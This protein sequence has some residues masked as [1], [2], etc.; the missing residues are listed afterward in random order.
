M[1]TNWIIDLSRK[2]GIRETFAPAKSGV[3]GDRV[4]LSENFV[5]KFFEGRKKKYYP[6]ELMV[7]SEVSEE[8]VAKLIDNGEIGESYYIIMERLRGKCLYSIW[9]ELSNEE[10]ENSIK[11]IADFLKKITTLKEPAIIDFRKELEEQYESIKNRITLTNETN[12]K[13][14]AF[15]D[16]N[17]GFISATEF[18][19]LSYID[20]HFDNFLYLDG[21]IKAID[22]EALKVAP[23]DYQMDR[24][25]R[26][27]RHP[28]VYANVSDK[29]KVKKRDYTN[30]TSLMARYYPEAFNF[31]NQEQRLRLYSLLYNL[32]VMVKHN[33][34]EERMIAL[35]LEDMAL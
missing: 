3:N 24:W 18:G 23:L 4:F 1:K 17:I 29:E 26:M 16:R 27:C 7:Y 8:Y 2:N 33:F 13:V 34:S 9:N 32:D 20:V 12:R 6:N 25:C 35:F 14:V 30:L 21:K 19:Y 10:R 28:D 31:G 22:F 5:I 11:Q 15:F